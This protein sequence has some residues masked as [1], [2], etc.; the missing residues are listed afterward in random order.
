MLSD[1]EEGT[2]HTY[3]YSYYKYDGDNYI[4]QPGVYEDYNNI[5]IDNSVLIIIDPWIDMPFSELN[6]VVKKNV[7]TYILPVAKR[8]SELG[9][10]VIIFTN[11]PKNNTYNTKIDE[12]LQNLVNEQN[13]KL[14]YHSDYSGQTERF[15]DEMIAEGKTNLIYTGFATELCVLYRPAGII[16]MNY[17]NVPQD[18][19][20]YIIPEATMATIC[21]DMDKNILMR[22]D[23]VTMLAQSRKADI[24]MLDNIMDWLNSN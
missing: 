9:G 13:V 21:D 12:N 23:I 18:I 22:N 4:V 14:V 24:I 2:L 1:S 19:S 7:S 15:A 11:D 8:F 5:T 20:C 6:N 3:Y 17:S 10:E 16:S